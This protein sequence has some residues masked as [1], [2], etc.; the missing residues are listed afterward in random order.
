MACNA[1]HVGLRGA[2][3]H[4]GV[5]HDADV[6]FCRGAAS[7][8]GANSPKRRGTRPMARRVLTQVMMRVLSITVPVVV[9]TSVACVIPPPL[10]LDES[11]SGVNATPV[12]VSSGP[13]PE[14]S[15]PG[16]LVMEHSDQRR[17]TL[18][19]SDSDVDDT[20]HVRIYRDY[21]MPDESN[22]VSSCTFPPSGERTRVGDCLTQS[23]CNGLAP[24]DQDN[25]VLE[26]VVADRAFLDES[27]PA[28]EGQ[29]AYRRLPTGTATSVR[30][31]IM[32]CEE[33]PSP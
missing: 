27:D 32:T 30:A 19:L 3:Q 10:Q 18:T 16:P 21:G 22:F 11:D 25:K 12:I 15:F 7:E 2:V 31:W 33:P 29:P 20:L 4:R 24:T 17:L 23:F 14:F 26:A 5:A 28:G 8:F 13:A 9:G 6:G 1:S